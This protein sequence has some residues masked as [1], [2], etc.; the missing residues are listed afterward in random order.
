[1]QLGLRQQ[2]QMKQEAGTKR[3]LQRAHQLL[4]LP[5]LHPA[6]CALPCSLPLQTLCSHVPTA[7]AAAVRYLQL[8]GQQHPSHDKG[9]PCCQPMLLLLLLQPHRQ[10]CWRVA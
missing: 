4:L 6:C 2:Q 7:A 10:C 8:H 5:A 1:V 3:R 9:H